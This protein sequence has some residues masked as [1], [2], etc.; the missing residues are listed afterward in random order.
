MMPEPSGVR[1][2]PEALL[3]ALLN[4]NILGLARAPD[5]PGSHL[6]QEPSREARWRRLQAALAAL[7]LVSSK[8]LPEESM[9]FTCGANDL[10]LKEK[11][12][13]QTAFSH[14]L[15]RHRAGLLHLE[16]LVM[17]PVPGSGCMVH[18]CH[19]DHTLPNSNQQVT[20]L[21]FG[22]SVQHLEPSHPS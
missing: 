21:P 14:A 9:I 12:L 20:P 11:Q 18:V 15:P 19:S 13:P 16:G 3:T 17:R 4:R 7:A 2:L 8:T 1:S 6:A 5:V 10:P 22:P